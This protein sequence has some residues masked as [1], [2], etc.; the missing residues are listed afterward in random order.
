MRLNEKSFRLPAN[1]QNL[2]EGQISAQVSNR[3]PYCPA[4][5]HHTSEYV[6]G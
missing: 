2:E 1:L 6:Q 3:E 4:R 5:D